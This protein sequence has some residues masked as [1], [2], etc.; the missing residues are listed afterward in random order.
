MMGSG[1]L[2]A[3]PEACLVGLAADDS[4]TVLRRLAKQ[5]ESVGLVRRTFT[6]AV[7]E[8]ERR[9]P[10]GLPTVVPVAIPHAEAGHVRRDGFAVATL[11][12]PVEFGVMGTNTETVAVEF[13]V[14]LL[15]VEAHEQVEV[16]TTLLEAFQRPDWELPLRAAQTPAE[17]AR[18]FDAHVLHATMEG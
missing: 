5:A 6:I 2:R 3:L 10:T 11:A 12:H 14:M 13:V 15:V 4:E 18:A 9:H 1:D 17:L 8:R 7:V 16:L